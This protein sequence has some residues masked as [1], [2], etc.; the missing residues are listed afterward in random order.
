MSNP[1]L[2]PADVL[3]EMCVDSVEAALAAQEGGANRVELCAD[4]LE[5]GITPSIGT[6][7]L[8]CERLA[9]PVNVIIRP[10][11]G[12][13]V[14]TEAEFGAMRRDVAAAKDAGAS[15]VVIGLL[16]PEGEVD[17]PRT[18]ALIA[19]ARPLTVTFHRA[20]DMARDPYAALEAL[21]ALGVDRLLTSGQEESALA[22]MD[23]IAELVRRAAGRLIVMPGGGVTPRNVGRIL[24][25][26]G[27]RE[28][29]VHIATLVDG[30]MRYRNPHCFMGGALRPAE[31]A[32]SVTTADDVRALRAAFG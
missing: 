30:P 15:G 28:V 10:R 9:I 32:R 4:L 3:L 22:G 31:F 27:A 7:S 26:T 18:R 6:I 5:G 21:L 13:F 16:T 2:L 25:A 17:L 8:A 24:S 11:G 19:A 20:F 1:A 12:D 14:N 29:H 23:L